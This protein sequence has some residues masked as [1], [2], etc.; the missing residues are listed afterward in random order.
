MISKIFKALSVG[1]TVL[2]AV[3]EALDPDS[4]EG[5]NISQREYI[6][7]SLRSGLAAIKAFGQEIVNEPNV[8]LVQMIKE[9][10]SCLDMQQEF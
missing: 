1:M 9:E 6:R 10:L 4:D 8:D 7:I 5:K 3:G 2:A